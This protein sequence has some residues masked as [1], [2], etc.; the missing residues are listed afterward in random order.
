[1]VSTVIPRGSRYEDIYRDFR[2]NV[3]GRC[4]IAR[5]VCDRHAANERR[6][7][8]IGEGDDGKV[9]TLSFREVQ[10]RANR[11]ANRLTAHGLC[12]GD[13][14]MIVLGQHPWAAIAHVACWKAGLVSVP[15]SPLFGTDALVYRLQHS[16]AKA[17]ISDLENFIKIEPVRDRCAALGEILLVDGPGPGAEDLERV[18]ASARDTFTT[19]DTH[20]DEPAI[21]NFTSGTTG[22]PKCAVQGHRTVWG[23]MPGA[24]FAYDFFPR[25]GDVMWSPAD[26]SWVA[27]LLGLLMPAWFHGVPVLSFRAP[28]FDPEQACRMMA[29]HGVSLALLTPT[30][31]KMIRQVPSAL[32]AGQLR[33]RAVL[34]GS[35]AVGGEL[36]EWARGAL[37]APVNEAFGQTEC[38]FVI[39]NNA[40]V[41]PV[42]P[43]SLG[44][45]LPG[46]VCAIVDD[47]GRPVQAGTA[48]NLAVRAPDPVMMLGYWNDP[49]AT[50]GK[51]V[52]EWLITGDTAVCD[53]EGYLWF[54]GRRDDLISSAGYRIGPGEIEDALLRHP[55]VAMAAA[56]G[57][58]DAERGEVVKAFVVLAAGCQGS[59]ALAEAMRARL[60]E[61][62]ARHEVPREVEF[63]DAL[64][65]TPTGKVLRRELRRREQER[66]LAPAATDG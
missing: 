16:G 55:G 28:R 24:E 61:R 8:L 65:L 26:W 58:P 52:G 44:R 45:P 6:V 42:R 63:V 50:R 9:W 29:R 59:A 57:V 11:L 22:N 1:M 40:S 7:A 60:R 32:D 38:N 34:S 20:A 13:R 53:D 14:V 12:R 56:I 23:Q 46:H 39:G 25:D 64:P 62:L 51:Y 66:R 48:G 49:D 33:L 2:W 15:T 19:L 5:D 31:L 35:E 37:R 47:E 3:P 4:N 30:M 10:R 54:R 17:L 27:G 21:F 41:M 36:H 43:G 18:L